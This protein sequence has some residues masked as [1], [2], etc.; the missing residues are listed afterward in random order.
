M[1]TITLTYEQQFELADKLANGRHAGQFR[2]DGKTPYMVHVNAVVARLK[3][4]KEKIVGKLHDILEDT[5]TT[6]EELLSLGFSKDI[7]RA[8]VLLTKRPGYVLE[9]YLEEIKKN[10]LARAVKIADMRANLADTPTRKQ[11]ER[12]SNGILYLTT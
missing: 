2:R 4:I 8:V 11:I 7:V 9:K 10:P 1:S 12:Y 6:E 5:D 3:T